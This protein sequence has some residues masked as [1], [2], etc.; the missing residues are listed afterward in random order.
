MIHDPIV[1]TLLVDHEHAH[2]LTVACGLER[3]RPIGTCRGLVA[4]KRA[5]RASLAKLMAR[6]LSSCFVPCVLQTK[7]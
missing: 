1:A 2:N 7:R 6:K 3:R 4:A 5:H